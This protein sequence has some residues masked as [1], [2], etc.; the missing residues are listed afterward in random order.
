MSMLTFYSIKLN[1]YNKIYKNIID[2]IYNS[3][4]DSNEHSENNSEPNEHSNSNSSSSSSSSSS[5]DSEDNQQDTQYNQQDTQYSKYI[6]LK[7]LRKYNMLK[8]DIYLEYKNNHNKNI[9][10]ESMEIYYYNNQSNNSNNNNNNNHKEN[11]NQ[12][13]FNDINQYPIYIEL[14]NKNKNVRKYNNHNTKK[15]LQ[16]DNQY[17][18]SIK[19]E[20]LL[21]INGIQLIFTDESLYY[22]ISDILVFLYIYYDFTDEFLLQRD[23]IIERKDFFTMYCIEFIS[24]YL[25]SDLFMKDSICLAFNEIT[26]IPKLTINNNEDEDDDEDEYDYLNNDSTMNDEPPITTETTYS[27]KI[28]LSIS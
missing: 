19:Y 27:I 3:S 9:K 2:S 10:L 25:Q 18:S 13:T 4:E 8:S 16:L 28:F 14:V 26:I 22:I 21:Y 15:K 1:I 24:Y 6:T 12:T 20:L 5:D 17:S 7:P 11:S 23:Y